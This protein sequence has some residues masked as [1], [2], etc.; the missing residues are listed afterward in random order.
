MLRRIVSRKNRR[1]RRAGQT[2]MY[3]LY[4]RQRNAK[5]RT[6]RIKHPASGI[7]LHNGYAHI[8][9]LTKL[10]YFRPHWINAAKS[11]RILLR[12][13]IVN[14]I[15]GRQKVKRRINAEQNHLNQPAL[16]R[17]FRHKRI[18]RAH[19]DMS[20]LSTRL[21]FLHILDKRSVHRVFPVILLIDKMYHAQIHVVR[22]QTRQQILKGL[23]APVHITG[24]LI[25][26]VLPCGTDMPL[27]IPTLP[28]SLQRFSYFRADIRF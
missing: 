12:K 5:R 2:V 22:L 23:P 21:Q 20:Y 15:R 9:L 19:A 3:T 13:I 24:P 10:I 4:R 11:V 25:L 28:S 8:I 27:N 1:N 26:P 14:I 16:R 17:F 18:V 6:R 7:R